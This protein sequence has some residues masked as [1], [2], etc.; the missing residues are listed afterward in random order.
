MDQ[1]LTF[2]NPYIHRNAIKESAYFCRDQNLKEISSLTIAGQ[3]ISIVGPCRIGKTSL[4][5]QFRYPSDSV[6]H[7]YVFLDCQRKPKASQAEL[8]QWMWQKI[9]DQVQ[10]TEDFPLIIESSQSF[11]REIQKVCSRGYQ[12]VI[13]FDEFEILASN[14]A[15]DRAFFTHL[16]SLSNNF[17]ISYI[18]SSS[19]PLIDL[20]YVNSKVSGS[21]FFKIFQQQRLGLL[22]EN[23]REIILGM[24]KQSGLSDLFFTDEETDFMLALA[25]NHPAFLQIA[26][27]HLLELKVRGQSFDKETKI[28]L[29][30]QYEQDAI[31]HFRYIWQKLDVDEREALYQLSTKQ[32]NKVNKRVLRRLEDECLV[33]KKNQLF[34]TVFTDFI[35]NQRQTR[36]KTGFKHHILK[37][38]PKHNTS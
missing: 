15:L 5:F 11:T 24:V 31:S 26:C 1:N 6:K 16:H 33:D 9:I 34:S 4:L 28:K 20:N 22:S 3:S 8:Y 18:T 38:L 12:I 21:P 10:Q 30:Q 23:E 36:R 7:L 25:G 32:V 17:P 29:R 14:P 2:I 37:L 19:K 13:Q 35:R 27:Y